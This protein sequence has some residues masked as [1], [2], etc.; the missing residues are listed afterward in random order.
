MSFQQKQEQMNINIWTSSSLNQTT[1]AIYI[2]AFIAIILSVIMNDFLTL[3]SEVDRFLRKKETPVTSRGVLRE[4][5]T[6]KIMSRHDGSDVHYSQL[7]F[8][9]NNFCEELRK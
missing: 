8:P 4:I 7:R 9:C 6:T 1:L 5:V 2:E 3:K